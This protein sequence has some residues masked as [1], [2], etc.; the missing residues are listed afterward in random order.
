MPPPLFINLFMF[1]GMTITHHHQGC[2]LIHHQYWMI[3]LYL[4]AVLGN[5]L[6]SWMIHLYLGEVLENF[7]LQFWMIHLYLGAVLESFPRQSW[8]IL[9]Y[10]G[11]VFQNWEKLVPWHLMKLLFHQ[12]LMVAVLGLT[13]SLTQL[14]DVS[15]NAPNWNLIL[16]PGNLTNLTP[17]LES[18]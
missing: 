8:M 3:H 7:R 11:Q 9:L 17:S 18:Q 5:F 6:Q 2:I 12:E 15:R 1:S 10:L 4:G 14:L 16:S 13:P